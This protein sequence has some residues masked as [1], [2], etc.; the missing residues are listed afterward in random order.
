MEKEIR[1]ADFVKDQTIKG[2]FMDKKA[3]LVSVVVPVYNVERFLDECV[4]SVLKQTMQDFDI[5]LVDD[6]STDSSGKSCDELAEKD[7]RI[8]VIHRKNG[9]LS[10]ARNTGFSAAT[11][12]YVY[13]LDSDD[14]IKS[15]TLEKLTATAE[16]EKADVVFFDAFVFFTNCEPDPNVYR[17]ERSK[18]Y[19]TKRGQD[20]LIDLLATDEY[21]TAVPLM[22]FRRA[23]LEDNGLTF[24]EGILHEDELFTFLVYNANGTVAHRHEEFYARR[25]RAASIMTASSMTRRYDSVYQIYF[26]LSDMYKCGELSGQAAE[27]YLARMARSVIAKYKM[28][29]K[30]GQSER[31]QQ[32]KLFKK[33]VIKCKGFDDM[34]L[35]IK[36]SS[37][38][39]NYYYRFVN[40]M[41][42]N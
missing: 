9:G 3:P 11:G 40:R 8:K 26:E 22:L 4:E 17:Y 31:A 38:I 10:A 41:K 13:Y 1:S 29:D 27:L 24:R 5:I 21:R 23:Y 2:L 16:K 20:M 36:C 15:D 28:L 14:W 34:K 6:G 33:D 18:Q 12:T 32:Q 30:K 25:M 7:N 37:G 35:K 42:H 19:E 39:M